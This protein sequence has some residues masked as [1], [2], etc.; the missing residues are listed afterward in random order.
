MNRY[1]TLWCLLCTLASAITSCQKPRPYLK[2]TYHGRMRGGLPEG[3][4]HYLSPTD[5][6]EYEGEW[7]QGLYHGYGRLR[8]H[9]TLYVGHFCRGA[10][11]GAGEM[12]Y[13]DSSRYEGYWLQGQR[14]GAG[15]LYLS[16]GTRY[17]GT[18]QA[19]TLCQGTRTDSCSSYCGTFNSRLE[20]HGHGLLQQLP[21][22]Y[23]EGRWEQGQREGFG[24]QVE[25]GHLVRCG[26]WRR[27]RFRGEQMLYT[28]DRVYGIDISKYQHIRGKRTCSIDWSDLRVTHLGHIG[29]KKVRG[30]VDYPVSFVYIKATEGQRTINAFYKDD[31][32]EARRH[33]YP[34]GAYHFFSTQPAATQANFFLHHAAPKAGDLPPMLDVELSDSRIRS[35]GGKEVLY[36]EMLTWLRMV[37]RRCGV[38]PIIYVGQDFVNRYM[39]Y[40]PDSLRAYSAWVARY[41]E[42]RPYV[43]LLHWQLSPDG[44]VRGIRGDVD[45]DVFNGTQEQFKA[46]LQQ[47]CVPPGTPTDRKP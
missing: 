33:G 29:K 39:A 46:Y 42:Y 37:E 11:H 34:V 20:P 36:R 23:Y 31:V 43:H 45:I 14:A 21:H 15:V 1:L 12:Y 13:P 47:H 4:G 32:R 30:T 27:N 18:W 17:Q 28:A 8:T 40:A 35:M 6:T 41:G 9:D 10:Y 25:P 24:L 26:I 44:R 16:H 38:R 22:L 3:Y 5:S 7:Q 2:G 19:D